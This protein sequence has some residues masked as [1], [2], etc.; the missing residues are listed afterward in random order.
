MT[1]SLD[2]LD[3]VGRGGQSLKEKWA[4]GPETYL[5]LGIDGFPN[6]FTSPGPVARRCWRTWCCTPN[7]TSTGSPTRSP[8]L[9]DRGA[10]AIEGTRRP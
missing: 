10:A 4:A 6:F 9:D 5:G 2:K 1:G 7:S 8:Y 3:I